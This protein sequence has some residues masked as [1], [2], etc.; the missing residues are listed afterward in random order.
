[1]NRFENIV[2]L[3]LLLLLGGCAAETE[4]DESGAADTVPVAETNA[5]P[6][7]L[8]WEELM[9]KGEEAK[10]EELY[11][12]Y[13]AELERKFQEEMADSEAGEGAASTQ[14]DPQSIASTI[15]EGSANDTMDQVGTFNV[16]EELNGK[17][18]R[19]PG[20]VVPFDFNSDANYS[21]FLL[22]PYFGAC[23][24]TP[25]PPPNQIVFVKA[26]QAANIDNIYDPVWVEGVLKTGRFDSDLA[27][28]AYELTLDKVEAYAY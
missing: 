18:I 23:L 24:H 11:S 9:P 27:N 2:P 25:P 12:D 20:Y 7:E 17:R 16:V 21:E 4:S 26:E 13:Y 19:L 3:A 8:T 10:L 28:S 14:S 22:V 1:M 5:K 15:V 6:I